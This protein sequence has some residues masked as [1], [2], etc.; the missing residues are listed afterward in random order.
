MS[1]SLRQSVT[2]FDKLICCFCDLTLVHVQ[3]AGVFAHLVLTLLCFRVCKHA[4]HKV[5]LGANHLLHSL[6]LHM[7]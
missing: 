6:M 2:A 7:H 4:A 3:V 1:S 5:K